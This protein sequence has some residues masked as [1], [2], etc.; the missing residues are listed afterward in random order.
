MIVLAALGARHIVQSVQRRTTRRLTKSHAE[1]VVELN[2]KEEI[3]TEL[4]EQ[5]EKALAEKR[6][7]ASSLEAERE[8]LRAALGGSAVP[9]GVLVHAPESPSDHVCE[10]PFILY[11]I[12]GGGAT[13]DEESS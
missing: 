9:G 2:R 13:G 11:C 1:L 4:T 5:A 10:D 12:N 6:A 3:L 8:D 7:E